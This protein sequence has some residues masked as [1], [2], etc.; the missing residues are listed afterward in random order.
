MKRINSI[1][2]FVAM[3]AGQRGATLIIALIFLLLMTLIGVTSM[4]STTLQERMAGNTRDRNLALQAAEAGLREGENWLATA[5]NHVT[6]ET[7]TALTDPAT[8]DGSSPHGAAADFTPALASNP[9]FYVGPSTQVV[10]G[11]SSSSMTVEDFYP[12]TAYAEGGADTTAVILQSMF[13]RIN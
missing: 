4:Q 10:Y 12:V 7:A 1:P 8:W 3:P 6:A 2:R 5:A 13:K 11:V 9:V